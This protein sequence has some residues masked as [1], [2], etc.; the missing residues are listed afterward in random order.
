M[1]KGLFRL[2]LLLAPLI[3]LAVVFGIAQPIIWRWVFDDTPS[4]D[5]VLLTDVLI[6]VIGLLALGVAAF[7]LL[8]YNI[9]RHFLEERL[10]RRGH[11]LEYTIHTNVAYACWDMYREDVPKAQKQ[12]VDPEIQG[13]VAAALSAAETAL[14]AA[15]KI[16]EERLCRAEN[17]LAYHLATM[18]KPADEERARRMANHILQRA[19]HYNKPIWRETYVWVLWRYERDDDDRRNAKKVLR[20]LLTDPSTLPE[21]R[22]RWQNTYSELLKTSSPLEEEAT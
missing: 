10:D 8:A 2:I 6:V 9:L 13:M 11:Y 18:A 22:E 17:N 3:A 5:A 15:K 20:E 12:P 7:G 4:R 21:Q 16:D 19:P 1:D 14:E